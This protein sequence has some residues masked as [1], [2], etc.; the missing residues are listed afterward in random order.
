M[1][2]IEDYLHALQHVQTPNALWECGVSYL[3]SQGVK[4]VSY[5]HVPPPGAPDFQHVRVTAEGFPDAWVDHYVR[6]RMFDFD[7]IP[8]LALS[9]ADPYCWSD[10]SQMMTLNNDQE[11]YLKELREA[12]LGNGVAIPVFGP[13]GRNGYVGLGF[14]EK[15]I[16]D[17]NLVWLKELQWV[18]QAT[19]MRLCE[20]LAST[21]SERPNLSPREREVLQWVARGKS[22][23]DI[24]DIMQISANT[25]DTYLRRIYTKLGVNDRVTAAVKGV[26]SGLILIA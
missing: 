23:P 21:F 2:G 18:C 14:G 16:D 8:A 20:M 9:R 24:S 13:G 5:H 3:R 7:P 11:H 22:N 19:H 12:Q 1:D 17:G 4:M 10:V 26:G 15:D 25:I 6:H